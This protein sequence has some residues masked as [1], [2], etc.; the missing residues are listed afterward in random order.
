MD[1]LLQDVRFGFRQLIK[2]PGFALVAIVS[3][4][5]GI[6]ANTAIFSL[7][8]KLLLRELPVA[9]PEQL[10][11]VTTGSGDTSF[12]YPLYADY[13]NRNDV[14]AGLAA[15]FETPFSLSDDGT[16]ERVHGNLVSGNY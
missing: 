2:N 14:F 8:D 3:L 9:H 5:L 7:M 10:V 11:T 6:G 4:A 1:R 15:Y 16:T 12:S 13:R